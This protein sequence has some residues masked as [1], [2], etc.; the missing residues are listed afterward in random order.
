L[1]ATTEQPRIAPLGPPYDPGVAAM[2]EKWM[3]PGSPL[4]PLV[5]F[6]TLA[7]HDE[8][9]SRMRVVGAGILGHGRVDARTREIMIERTCARCGAEYEWGVHATAFG[10]AVGL[11]DAQ[12]A[13]TAQAD[14]ND[15]VWSALDALLVRLAD[16]LHDGCTVSDALWSDLSEHYSH[17]QLLELVVI[18]GW[19]RLISGV[20][21]ACHMTL[22]PWAARF[23]S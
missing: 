7:L 3:P 17:D 1:S 2:L 23:P 22:E 4:E 19:Y 11:T 20:I 6:R 8:L 18:A 12:L 14:S 13:A 16:E 5:L 9:F 15:P 21:N 10:N